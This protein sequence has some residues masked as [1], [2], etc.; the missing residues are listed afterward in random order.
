MQQL[1]DDKV[2]PQLERAGVLPHLERAGSLVSS[3]QKEV[4]E[5][6]EQARTK[7]SSTPQGVTP[8]STGA[9]GNLIDL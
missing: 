9:N 2:K 6:V 8:A 3:V 7:L 4:A 1:V 5:R